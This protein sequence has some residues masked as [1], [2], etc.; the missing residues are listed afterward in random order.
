MLK[1]G[2][3]HRDDKGIG[4]AELVAARKAVLRFEPG[5][6]ERRSLVP[7]VEPCNLCAR[8]IYC[9]GIG[10]LVYG[11]ADARFAALIG[12]TRRARRRIPP[13]AKSLPPVS[14]TW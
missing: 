10:T 5:L 12:A 4:H 13:A 7:S 14:A 3:T 8:N 11:P 6:M 2:N 9:A 1:C